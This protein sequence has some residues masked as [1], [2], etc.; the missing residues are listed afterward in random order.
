M[1]VYLSP[2][3]LAPLLEL[4]SMDSLPAEQE[5][6]FRNA[7]EKNLLPKIRALKVY[8]DYLLLL[9]QEFHADSD[10]KWLA[11]DWKSL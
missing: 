4:E 7:A 3:K 9:P 5:A 10:W 2:G 1:P 6:I 11:L 8:P